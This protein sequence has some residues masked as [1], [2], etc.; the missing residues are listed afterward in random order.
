MQVPVPLDNLQAIVSPAT[1]EPVANP[2]AVIAQSLRQ[3]VAGPSLQKLAV[4]H[5]SAAIVADDNTRQTPTDLIIPPLLDA[6]NAAGIHD[7]SVKIVI[8]LGTHRP[9]T[10]AEVLS[11]FGENVVGRVEVINHDWQN[12]HALVDVGTTPEGG[13]IEL[14]RHVADADLVIGVGSIVPHHTCGF[15]GGSKIIAPGV[16]SGATIGHMHL[17]SATTRLHY[18]GTI[19]NVVRAEMDAIGEMAGLRFV[20]NTI[21]NQQGKVVDVVAG[22]PKEALLAGAKRSR[23]VWEVPAPAA[24]DI[25]VASSHPCDLDFW[26]AHKALYPSVMVGRA[27]GVIVLVTPCPESIS[28]THPVLWDLAPL[29]PDETQAAVQAGNVDDLPAAALALTWAKVRKHAAI[30]LV[31]DG[32]DESSAEALGFQKFPDVDHALAAAFDRMG[33]QARVAILTHAPDTLPRMND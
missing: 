24:M 14:N 17:L 7:E 22:A 19:E 18:L 6:L 25:V 16:A 30:F 28:P 26:Q 15:S 1:N 32:L 5:R 27:G 8:S 20:V 9:M 33:A 10:P 11:K 4:E 29:S 13:Q 21:L 3:P 23:N 31:S 2:A 12:S